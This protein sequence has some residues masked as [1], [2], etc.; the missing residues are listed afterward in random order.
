MSEEEIRKIVKEAFDEINQNFIKEVVFD[1]KA[2]IMFHGPK[3]R[4]VG[5]YYAVDD[6]S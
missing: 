6:W 3:R 4:M 2:P 1:C 5:P